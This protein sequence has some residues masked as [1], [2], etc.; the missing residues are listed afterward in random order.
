MDYTYLCRNST[1]EYLYIYLK[2]SV[3]ELRPLPLPTNRPTLNPSPTPPHK[4]KLY[5]KYK[6][7]LF[8]S[9]PDMEL[10]LVFTLGILDRRSLF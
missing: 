10:H 4:Y 3:Q 6:L 5:T 2:N 1:L 8:S 7:Y 9:E